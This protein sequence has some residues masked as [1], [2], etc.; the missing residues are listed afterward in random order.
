MMEEPG[1]S[2]LKWGHVDSPDRGTGRVTPVVILVVI[3]CCKSNVL[4]FNSVMSNTSNPYGA[5]TFAAC[6][7]I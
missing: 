5:G 4:S 6:I 1:V 7:V 3:D 2:K